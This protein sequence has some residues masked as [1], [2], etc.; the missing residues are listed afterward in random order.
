MTGNYP[1]YRNLWVDIRDGL[2]DVRRGPED[3]HK[4]PLFRVSPHRLKKKA[5]ITIGAFSETAAIASYAPHMTNRTHTI[6][7]GSGSSSFTTVAIT[8]ATSAWTGFGCFAGS[9]ASSQNFDSIPNSHCD[10][11]GLNQV[12]EPGAF[13]VPTDWRG[14]PNRQPKPG[15]RQTG[16]QRLC[17]F[18]RLLLGRA[19]VRNGWFWSRH[20]F[21]AGVH[22]GWF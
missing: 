16:Q 8:G 1:K 3:M 12:A 9:V 19:G 13:A 2:K 20:L 18:S 7:T 11:L 5:P 15:R 14:G 22:N 6:R 10:C 17:C 21:R 4:P